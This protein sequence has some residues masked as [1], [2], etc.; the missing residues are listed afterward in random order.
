M[1]YYGQPFLHIIDY[2][3]EGKEVFC[4]PESGVYDTDDEKLILFMKKNKP[5]IRA[6]EIKGDIKGSTVITEKKTDK[7]P[8]KSNKKK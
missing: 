5:H 8:R 1:R 3:K 7:K 6:E 4:F 2:S